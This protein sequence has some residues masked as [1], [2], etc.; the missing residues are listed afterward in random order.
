[1]EV[2]RDIPVGT[3]NSDIFSSLGYQEGKV[4]AR[5]RSRVGNLFAET[6]RLTN[7]RAVCERTSLQVDKKSIVL[8]RHS[9]VESRVLKRVLKACSKAVAF[10]VTLGADVDALIDKMQRNSVQDAFLVDA[11]ASRMAEDAAESFQR[12]MGK[13]LS[14][15]EGM[16]LRYSPGY[17]DWPL[18]Q[19]EMIFS[20]VDGGRI[21]VS[22]NDHCM[23]QPRKSISGIFGVGKKDLVE[24]GKNACD[25][26]RR[27]DCVYRRSS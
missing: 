16:T 20:I 3:R 9:R 2:F 21:G 25:G 6:G 7:A 1:M 5:V 14:G 23:M 8:N 10:V 24:A 11:I 22:L 26:C 19:Q 17:C 13:G 15:E 4:P 12:E 18:S 27:K